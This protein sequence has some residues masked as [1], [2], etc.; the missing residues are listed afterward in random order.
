MSKYIVKVLA[1]F[2][3]VTVAFIVIVSKTSTEFG[4]FFSSRADIS[5]N[6]GT[7]LSLLRHINPCEN[8]LQKDNCVTGNV[9]GLSFPICTYTGQED[10]F[11]SGLLQSGQYWESA[12]VVD[13][14]QL[15]RNAD[16]N[17]V[18][19]DVG[20]NVGAY[21]LA[22]AHAGHRVISLEP[23]HETMK[24]LATSVCRGNITDRITLLQNAISNERTTLHLGVNLSNRG[25][26]FLLTANYC[27]EHPNRTECQQAAVQTVTLDDLLTVLKPLQQQSSESLKVV[28]KVDVQANEMRVFDPLTCS[29]FFRQVN[30]TAIQV[31]WDLIPPTY[32]KSAEQRAVVD[33]VLEFLYK[34]NYTVH[35]V[36]AERRRLSRDWMK[37][38]YDIMILRGRQ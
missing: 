34:Q 20:T 7:I 22:A 35:S 37:W 2:A 15:L 29:Q 14:L 33:G 12:M 16:P 19:V 25:D 5:T 6:S 21:S 4:K 27:R 38:P 8:A 18:L 26:S 1:A 36:G 10:I 31:E 28:M 32:G 23:N 13:V 9:A 24:H 17:S 11:V 3:V 30:V